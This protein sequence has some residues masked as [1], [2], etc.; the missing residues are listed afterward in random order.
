[1]A[2]KDFTAN[3]IRVA[4]LILTGGIGVNNLGL[5]VYS[6]S[7]AS[8][9]I[10]GV[11]D[12]AMYTNVGKDA[13]IFVSG[14]AGSRDGAAGGS[15]LFG[16]DVV[17]SGSMLV[18]GAPGARSSISGSI[19]HTAGGLSYLVA[20]AGMTISSGTNGQ[21]T[22]ATSAGADQ[23]LF[24]QVSVDANGGS[25]SGGPVVADATT[26]TLLLRAGSNITLTADAGADSITIAAS[27]GG[28]AGLNYY[29]EFNG[30]PTLSPTALGSHSVVIGNGAHASLSATGSIIL[31]TNTTGSAL[32]GAIGGGTVNKILSS[33]D[34]SGIA[35]GRSNTIS[36][37]VG[38]LVSDYA[39]IGGGF[40]NSIV[41][42]LQKGGTESVLVGGRAN[43]V[44]GSPSSMILGGTA[45]LTNE[46]DNIALIGQYLTASKNDIVVLGFGSEF[47]GSGEKSVVVSGSFFKSDG[48]QGG[49]ISGSITRTS[50]NLPYLVGEGG[51]KITTSSLGQITISGSA[52]GSG[53]SSEWTRANSPERLYPNTVGSTNVLIGNTA[54]ATANIVLLQGGGATFNAQQNVGGDFRVA[55]NNTSG[56]IVA[57]AGTEQLALLSTG[58]AAAYS[59]NGGAIPADIGLYVSGSTNGKRTGQ[60]R[61]VAAFQG[62]LVSSGT[63]F[64]NSIDAGTIHTFGERNSS[65]VL[66]CSSAA[67]PFFNNLV[68][69]QTQAVNGIPHTTNGPRSGANCQAYAFMIDIPEAAKGMEVRIRSRLPSGTGQVHFKMSG[70]F[71]ATGQLGPTISPTA[72]LVG[73]F[74]TQ[75]CGT[76]YTD[77]TGSFHFTQDLGI[78]NAPGNVGIFAIYRQD[79]NDN[80]LNAILNTKVVFKM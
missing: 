68:Q 8:N 30:S 23:N 5:S 3:Q 21:I 15:V 9:N 11:S 56:I 55:S 49:A 43:T 1:M 51:I 74:G 77:H 25:A 59:Y 67:M 73:D 44:I 62:D 66:S 29:D 34:Y 69:M 53:G 50:T 32:Y 58:S 36:G 52:G 10:G 63:F 54:I 78:A 41:D 79:P 64:A 14:T 7:L 24:S 75:N 48:L 18:K 12:S 40:S 27:A 4:K 45:N 6:G 13:T 35:S 42:G 46:K 65:P 76:G 19:H 72:A 20:G 22:L 70:S 28:D 37:S 47:A 33:S 16:G 38:A 80:V 60:P 39:F 61:G 17:V 71:Q 2:A 57:D 31:G 26:D